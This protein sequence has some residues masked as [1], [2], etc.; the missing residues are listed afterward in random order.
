MLL[1]RLEFLGPVLDQGRQV[2]QELPHIVCMVVGF[3]QLDTLFDGGIG[4]GKI[5]D[6]LHLA[7]RQAA[8]IQVACRDEDLN[9][10]VPCQVDGS[11]AVGIFKPTPRLGV[12]NVTITAPDL[13]TSAS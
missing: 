7:V 11:L 5:H 13:S 12:R 6:R 10:L 1:R 8:G 4:A 9:L 3:N 2:A